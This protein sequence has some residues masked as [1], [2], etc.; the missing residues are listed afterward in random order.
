MTTLAP[1]Q[2]PVGR[3][4]IA[5]LYCRRHK[6]RCNGEFP[7][8]RCTRKNLDCE[9][10]S[11]ARWKRSSE[12]TST[13]PSAS[14]PTPVPTP[15]SSSSSP[16][17]RLADL[18]SPALDPS[19][20]G[21]LAE[22][23]A[24]A[25]FDF[26]VTHCGPHLGPLALHFD[27]LRDTSPLLLCSAVA[28]AYVNVPPEAG[29]ACAEPDIADALAALA[30]AH[31]AASLLAPRASGLDALGVL[32]AALWG[33]S[34]VDEPSAFTL[35]RHAGALLARVPLGDVGSPAWAA[36]HICELYDGLLCLGYGLPFGTYPRA[37]EPAGLGEMVAQP[38]LSPIAAQAELVSLIRLVTDWASTG[39][40]ETLADLVLRANDG[41]EDWFF[42]WTSGP[43]EYARVLGG[44]THTLVL[45]HHVRL[46]IN[47]LPL[48]AGVIGQARAHRHALAAAAGIID[49]YADLDTA[50]RT[51]PSVGGTILAHAT[52]CLLPP[53]DAGR[54]P[55]SD[56]TRRY[57]ETGLAVLQ[58]DALNQGHFT[59]RFARTMERVLA[60]RR[61]GE[62]GWPE[63]IVLPPLGAPFALI[64]TVCNACK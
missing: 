2:R 8:K 3:S 31:I 11:S 27:E 29:I 51:A 52:M 60:R 46:S 37:P 58:T 61:T 17:P 49:A 59:P 44:H 7:C 26:F 9:F 40:L 6:V 56:A 39:S 32:V 23:D 55:E 53:A 48:Q 10:A 24:R 13:P 19:S 4:S 25:L 15:P 43:S 54:L 12:R 41:L 28:A 14:P 64:D 47:M 38:S 21:I 57:Y 36:A 35:V 34:R 20:A 42:K 5:C 22:S 63:G 45:A 50:K 62:E 16:W 33:I 18:L 1:G 30:Y